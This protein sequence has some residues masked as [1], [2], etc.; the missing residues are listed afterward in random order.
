MHVEGRPMAQNELR[1]LVVDDTIVYRRILTTIIEEISGTVVAATAPN[2]KIAL[3]KMESTEVDLVLLDVEMPVLD[4][5]KTLEVMRE[6]FPEVGVIMVSGANS[7]A[8]STTIRALER[9]ALDFVPKPEGGDLEESQRQLIQHIRRV[10]Q[11]FQTRR[12]LRSTRKP[13]TARPGTSA[14]LE[15]TRPAARVAVAPAR[16]P[17]ERHAGKRAS[18]VEVVVIGVS[19]GGP[20]ALKEVIPR[21]TTAL[22]VP[23]LIVQHMPPLFTASLADSLDR[24]S[25]LAVRE[26]QEGDPLLANTVLIAPGGK[27][28][29]IRSDPNAS[30]GPGFVVALN[31]NPPEQNCRPSVNVLFRSVSTYFGGKIL[32]VVMTGMGEDGCEGVRAMKRQGCICLTQEESTCVVYGMPRAVDEA[33]LSDE[34]VPLSQLAERI[35]HLVH[36]PGLLS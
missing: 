3:A 34:R 4:G 5:L 23:V 30:G 18:K 6:R 14:P 13:V 36:N 33:G 1:V 9:G 20:N 19:T 25:A 35:Q 8:A 28:M 16:P 22:N 26:A 32:A 11:L 24:K 10:V 31:E 7:S 12:A 15:R 21:L 27:H 29:V 2:G 17:L